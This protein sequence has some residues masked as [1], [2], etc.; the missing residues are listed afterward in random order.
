[1]TGKER[2]NWARLVVRRLRKEYPDAECA[3]IHKNAFELTVATILSAQCTDEMVNK[4]T[5]AL[6]ARYPTPQ[7]LARASTASR[8]RAA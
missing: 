3:L 2:Q 8:P 5:P 6:F 1:M 4:P 7:K